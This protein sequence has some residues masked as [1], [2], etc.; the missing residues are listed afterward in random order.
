MG[1]GRSTHVGE[2]LQLSIS[3]YMCQAANFSG[4][5]EGRHN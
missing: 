3:M 5:Y 2:E 4:Y 1:R